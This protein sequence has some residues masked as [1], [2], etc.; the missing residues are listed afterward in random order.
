MPMISGLFLLNALK[1]AFPD[2]RVIV[3]TDFAHDEIQEAALQQGSFAFVH[4]PLNLEEFLNLVESA[5]EAK[6]LQAS[7]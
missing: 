1:T 2:M 5:V 7:A 3:I 6:K 4:K